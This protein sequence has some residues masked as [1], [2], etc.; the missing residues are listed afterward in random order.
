MQAA[1]PQTKLE[2][3]EPVRTCRAHPHAAIRLFLPSRGTLA[4]DGAFSFVEAPL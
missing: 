1:H 2:W 4:A 3:L